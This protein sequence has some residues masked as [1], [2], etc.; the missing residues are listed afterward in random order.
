MDVS[1]KDRETA[2]PAQPVPRTFWLRVLAIFLPLALLVNGFLAAW[3][4]LDNSTRQAVARS[5]Q[6][7]QIWMTKR[8]ITQ[9]FT[10]IVSDIL[11]LARQYT[12]YE[13]M[14]LAE[15]EK[16]SILTADYLAMAE[17]KQIYDQ[18]RLLDITGMESIR[19]DYA[20][21]LARAVSPDRLQFKGRHSYFFHSLPLGYGEVYISRIDLNLEHGRVEY[22]IK[23]VLRILTPVMDRNGVKTGVLVLN[24]LARSLLAAI[25]ADA[26]VF[27]GE[28]TVLDPDSYWLLGKTPAD[29]WGFI[30]EA[31]RHRTFS[32]DFPAAW[33]R[34]SAQ[35]QG[36]VMEKGL[37][38]TFDTVY[39]MKK[40]RALCRQRGAKLESGGTDTDP[41][42]Y[43]WKIVSAL[44]VSELK[45]DS[46]V[47]AVFG[48]AACV[49]LMILSLRASHHFEQRLKAEENLREKEERL[50]A[51]SQASLDALV[52]IDAGGRVL[53]WNA[54]AEEMFGY[55]AEEVLGKDVHQLIAP[56]EDRAAA[57]EGMR[58]FA[59]TGQ[60]K[61]VDSVLEF[62]ALRKD[63]TRFPIGRAVAAFAH[64]GR[65][66]AVAGIRDITERKKAE[67]DLKM[68]N[69]KLQDLGKLK[70]KFLGM[71]A[72]DMRNPLVS[73]RGFSEMMVEGDLGPVSGPQREFLGIIQN[74]AQEM[75]TLINDLLDIS[76]IESGR[77]ELRKKPGNLKDLVEKRLH[78]MGPH[79]EKKQVVFHTAFETVPNISM[80]AARV[81]QIIDNL[82]SNARKIQP[83]GVHHQHPTGTSP[84]VRGPPHH[85]PGRR[86][87]R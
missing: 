48:A 10:L 31:R 53:F 71:A 87:S 42:R 29:E 20:G 4:H 28:L 57:A 7:Q 61:V 3:Y 44:P 21:G 84:T 49:L 14:A 82:L 15:D 64:A 86:D 9:D 77:L 75:L 36:R 52:L 35:T 62:E 43:H 70:D 69:A 18:I 54:A 23:P 11:T 68:A 32:R 39:P 13:A 51:M 85:R 67:T 8:Q 16:R 81:A 37:L 58:H 27:P 12:R 24:Y 66:F 79:A 22:P 73:I 60:G 30:L 55:R 1:P 19:V 65:W 83:G 5:R 6:W 40:V 59:A 33:Q 80:D 46:R 45:S 63:G 34:V 47:Y 2:R 78:L 25:R 26:S 17:T 74:T 76:V 50:H 56:P 41:A 72:H 38:F